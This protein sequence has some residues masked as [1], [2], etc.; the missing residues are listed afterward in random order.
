MDLKNKKVVV[1]G[2]HGFLGKAVCDELRSQGACVHTF[3]SSQINLLDESILGIASCSPEIVIH[4]AAYVGGI[5]LNRKCPADLIYRN[6]M[7]GMNLI[8]EARTFG[9]KMVHVGSVCSYPKFCSPP[10]KE[11]DLW[12]GYPEETN[13]PYG[14]AKKAIGVALDAYYQQ[15]GL[16]SAYVIP[17]NLYGPHDNFDLESSHVIPAM[18]R[19]F[20]EARVQGRKTVELWGTGMASREFLFV[21]DAARGIVEAAKRINEPIPINLGTG[22]EIRI[23]DLAV[24]ISDLIGFEGRIV[25]DD[26][27]PDGQPRR[28]LDVSRAQEL[29]GWKA[30]VGL[31]EGLRETVEWFRG[32]L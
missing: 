27:M 7:M 5:G 10:F 32:A 12:N 8:E 9:W 4:L 18:I 16:E 28:C 25:W 26:S 17:V 3:R 24:K 6:L 21:R 22:S 19:K 11:A 30:E 13:A 2:G 29:L 1:T 14:V 23:Y 20:E 15:H 31:D